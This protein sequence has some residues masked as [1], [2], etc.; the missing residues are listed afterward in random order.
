MKKNIVYFCREYN[1]IDHVV[2][3][4]DELLKDKSVSS[5]CFFNYN[6]NKSFTDDYRI[7]YLR[8]NRNFTYIEY[9]Q[10]LNVRETFLLSFLEILKK[11]HHYFHKVKSDYINNIYK[12]TKIENIG[13]KIEDSTFLFDHSNSVFLDV[14]FEFSN[15]HKIPIGLLMHGLDPTENLLMETNMLEIYPLDNSWEHFNKADA[16]F[17]NN[18]H[19]KKRS[20]AHGVSKEIINIIGSARFSNKWSNILENITP[21]VDLPTTSPNFVKIVIQKYPF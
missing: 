17:V 6:L 16:Y 18:E 3:I 4:A 21:D 10:I 12:K 2:P 19:Y 15:L 1:D 14:V 11:I 5:L 20:L 7:S 9:Y 8:R 13:V